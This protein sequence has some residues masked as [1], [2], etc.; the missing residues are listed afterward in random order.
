M[1]KFDIAFNVPSGAT[2]VEA[3]LTL[4]LTMDHTNSGINNVDLHTVSV[5]WGEGASVSPLSGG[6][7]APAQTNDATWLH[8]FYNN[9]FWTTAGGDFSASASATTPINGTGIYNWT[10]AQLVTD[11][12]NWLNSPT[13][14]FGWFLT[15]NETVLQS[16]MRFA[17]RE[18]VATISRPLLT[19]IHKIP[20]GIHESNVGSRCTIM[21]NPSSGK[22]HVT[23][24]DVSNA[25]VKIY[26]IVG[27]PVFSQQIVADQLAVDLS[28]EPGGVY[29]YELLSNKRL[30]G[31]GKIIIRN[32]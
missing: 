11:I 7:G 27:I 22:M 6:S 30:V 3:T 20:V 26:N 12:Q 14:N 2:I 28:K 15:G 4:T 21:P 17:S 25:E 10:S 8:T 5:D 24:R 16:A 1:I 19:I 29:F 18:I 23:V 9:A 31:T 32:Q 13:S